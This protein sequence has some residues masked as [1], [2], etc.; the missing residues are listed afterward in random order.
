MERK[1]STP[2]DRAE[3]QRQQVKRVRRRYKVNLSTRRKFLP[4][5]QDHIADMV[6]VLKLAGYSRVQIGSVVGISRGQVREV[7]EDPAV[8]EKL[9]LLRSKLPQAALELL[10]GYSIE[11]VQSIVA[12]MRESG[13]DSLVLK[14]AG[15]ILDRAGVV[16]AS[17][18]E[19][20]NV[21][22]EVTTFADDGIVDRL[23]E[24]PVHVQEEAAQIIEKLEEL[25]AQNADGNS[26]PE[27]EETTDE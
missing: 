14:A 19:R 24:A 8:Q 21:I 23:R 13:D 1:R 2:S 12:V 17:R 20:H 10:H 22:E 11:A 26:A 4:G 9:V 18:Q 3:T 27:P 15:E 5:E 6:I 7:L 25:M 16:K